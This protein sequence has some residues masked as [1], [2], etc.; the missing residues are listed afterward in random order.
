MSQFVEE[1]AAAKLGALFCCN[2]V[3]MFQ[4]VAPEV[5]YLWSLVVGL[6]AEH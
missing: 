4:T 1:V 6:L 2:P 5:D 3:H